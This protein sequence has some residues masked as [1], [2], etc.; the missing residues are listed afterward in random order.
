M[1]P[2]GQSII[3]GASSE[4]DPIVLVAPVWKTQAWYPTLLGM[5]MDFP[6]IL[7]YQDGLIQPTIPLAAP[8]VEPQLAAWPISGNN[9]GTNRFLAQA[10]SSYSIEGEV[11]QDIRL[12][13]WE[14]GV[15]VLS[16]GCGSHF[17]PYI[18]DVVKF[19]SHFCD[20]G[21]QYR[22]LNSYR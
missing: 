20:E 22:S 6:I 3:P 19:L 18:R 12:P 1:E 14:M 7:H 16:K 2:S 4:S 5:L 8:E 15:L 13:F 17:G 21:Y 9:T 10:Q 11:I